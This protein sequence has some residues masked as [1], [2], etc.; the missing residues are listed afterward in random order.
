MGFEIPLV[1]GDRPSGELEVADIA[2]LLDQ[3]LVP[4]DPVRPYA[5]LLREGVLSRELRGYLN[6]SLDLVFRLDDGRYVLA[7]YKTNRLG[8]SDEVL[9]AWHYRSEA[10]QAEMLR[11]HYPLQ[12]LLYSVALHRYLRWRLPGYSAARNLGG[13]LYLFLRGMSAMEPVRVRDHPCGV[14]SW[15]PPPRLVEGLSDLFAQGVQ[16]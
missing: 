15:C 2:A 1:G 6:G 10:L 3:H 4:D 13:V 11:A 12:A 14:W 7:D 16:P 9:T 5:A 8:S